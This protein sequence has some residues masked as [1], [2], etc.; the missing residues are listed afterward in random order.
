VNALTIKVHDNQLAI[1]MGQGKGHV[2]LTKL[3]Q[4]ENIAIG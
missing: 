2:V 1:V 4:A 3:G